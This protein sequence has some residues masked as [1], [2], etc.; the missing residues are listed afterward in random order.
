[1][2]DI[3]SSGGWL[4]LEVRMSL[5]I[6]QTCAQHG[7]SQPWITPSLFQNTNDT[8]IIDEFTLGQKLDNNT[9]L[10]IMQN[11][12]QTWITEDDFKAIKAA[13]LNHVR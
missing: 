13:G 5:Q 7:I 12:W 9:A 6:F 2:L 1:M 10:S 3:H 4:V 11:H 8:S